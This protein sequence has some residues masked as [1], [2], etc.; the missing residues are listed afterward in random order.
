MSVNRLTKSLFSQAKGSKSKT[1]C[2]LLSIATC[3]AIT[4]YSYAHEERIDTPS[5]DLVLAVQCVEERSTGIYLGD[6]IIKVRSNSDEI[7]LR[8]IYVGNSL[9]HDS[10]YIVKRKDHSCTVS[11]SQ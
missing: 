1:L 10:L 6:Y 9:G 2:A 8:L 3:F 5:K 11:S 7:F 4:H